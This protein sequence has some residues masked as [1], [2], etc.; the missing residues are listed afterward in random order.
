VK[1]LG[2][3][4]DAFTDKNRIRHVLSR[5]IE[6]FVPT[7]FVT[8]CLLMGVN[9]G[10]HVQLSLVISGVIAGLSTLGQ[11]L[12]YEFVLE[13]LGTV[14]NPIFRTGPY[15]ERTPADGETYAKP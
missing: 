1:V 12:L 9:G 13:P 2:F 11:F 15:W 14:R 4:R 6:G 5:V 8:F 10:T 7:A 3:I